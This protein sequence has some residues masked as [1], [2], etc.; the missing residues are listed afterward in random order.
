[1]EPCCG[2][3]DAFYLGGEFTSHNFVLVLDPDNAGQKVTY[4]LVRKGGVMAGGQV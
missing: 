1:M 3:Y 2:R 4:E